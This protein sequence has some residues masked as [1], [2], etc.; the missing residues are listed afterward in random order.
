MDYL[1][2]LESITPE[3]YVSLC[4]AVEKGKWP[5]GEPLTRKQKE[6]SLEAIIAYDNRNHLETQRVGYIDKG[7]KVEK[8]ND[9][10]KKASTDVLKWSD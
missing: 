9:I 8:F 3:I 10:S 2:L 4:R 6:Q 5:D 1:E 7:T